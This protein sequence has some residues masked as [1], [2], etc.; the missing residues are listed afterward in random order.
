[1]VSLVVGMKCKRCFSHICAL[2]KR[3]LLGLQWA[4][5]SEA[6]HH[7]QTAAH[8]SHLLV[9]FWQ[10]PLRCFSIYEVLYIQLTSA[11]AA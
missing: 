7:Q 4:A 10:P 8:R 1:M 6:V 9:G 2:K 5:G 3:Q 11:M